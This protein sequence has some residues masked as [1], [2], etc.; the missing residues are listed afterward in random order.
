MAY[1]LDTHTLLWYIGGDQKLSNSAAQTVSKGNTEVFVSIS[2]LWEI[3]IKTNIGKL[4]IEDDIS[5]LKRDI[6]TYG[7]KLIEVSNNQYKSPTSPTSNKGN[8]PPLQARLYLW[9]YLTIVP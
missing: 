7:F 3:S 4:E 5:Q 2:S 6:D 9:Q 1:L 8:T